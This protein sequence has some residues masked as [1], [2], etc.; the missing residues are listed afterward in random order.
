M[1]GRHDENSVKAEKPTFEVSK[2]AK[3]VTAV[4]Y[5]SAQPSFWQERG[6]G[7]RQTPLTKNECSTIFLTPEDIQNAKH[8][9]DIDKI[10]TV[11]T[12]ERWLNKLLETHVKELHYQQVVILGSGFDIRPFKKNKANQSD[13]QHSH[14]YSLVK[15]WEID[16]AVILD[17]KEQ[18]FKSNGL[19][20]NATYIRADYTKENFIEKLVSAGTKLDMPTLIIWEGNLMYLDKND[21]LNVVDTIKSSFETVTIA[22]DYFTQSFLDSNN[23]SQSN[24]SFKPMW[25][26]GIDDIHQFAADHGLVVANVRNIRD[27]ETEY[28]VDHHPQGTGPYSICSLRK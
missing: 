18:I 23:S 3:P 5:V 26:T 11:S 14:S 12:R 22:F 17:E 19:D 24:S 13:K 27:L 10:K 4:K 20:K 6:C 8:R 7:N 2:T 15:F 28:D 21:A 25:K 1:N 9:P 16:K